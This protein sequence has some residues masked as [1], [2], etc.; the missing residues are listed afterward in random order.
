MMDSLCGSLQKAP[1]FSS[2]RSLATNH[3]CLSDMAA[4]KQQSL[5]LV[6]ASSVEQGVPESESS[7]VGRLNTHMS[8]ETKAAPR[9]HV[10]FR[11]FFHSVCTVPIGW[12]L[13]SY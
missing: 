1:S 12:Q 10:L 4:R 5:L 9:K 2:P 6:H 7:R 3:R 8:A 11:T 13:S